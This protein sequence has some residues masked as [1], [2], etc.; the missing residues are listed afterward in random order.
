M[1]ISAGVNLLNTAQQRSENASREIAGQFEKKTDVSGT[2]YKS[3][4]L[5]KP[6]ID[7]KRAELEAS[8]ATKII[9]ADKKTVGSILDIN[10]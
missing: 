1:N 3:E 2:S 8:A 9:E 7:L 10:A 5:I 6:V 4:S